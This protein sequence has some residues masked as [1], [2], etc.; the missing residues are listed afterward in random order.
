VTANNY[1]LRLA[2]DDF[3]ITV[4][5]DGRAIVGGTEDEAVARTM[6]AKYVGA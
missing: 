6:L 1:L 3:L 4:F 5:A 2:V